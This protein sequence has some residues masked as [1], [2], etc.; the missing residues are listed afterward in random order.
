LLGLF[1]ILKSLSWA[2]AGVGRLPVGVINYDC[3]LFLFVFY[4]FFFLF[5]MHISRP[6]P[7]FAR[8]IILELSSIFIISKR[9]SADQDANIFFSPKAFVFSFIKMSM[10]LG[11]KYLK[12]L[13]WHFL[14]KDISVVCTMKSQLRSTEKKWKNWFGY[15][16]PSHGTC[17]K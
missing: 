17:S 6:H 3:F 1:L 11:R 13:Y 7:S 14:A 15:P 10:F 4:V 8:K 16:F 2:G 12:N 9:Q 5:A